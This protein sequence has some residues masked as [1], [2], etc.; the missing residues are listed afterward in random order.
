MFMKP[1]LC[2]SYISGIG[3]SAGKKKKKTGHNATPLEFM[4]IYV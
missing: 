1:I 3:N 2:V 4:K